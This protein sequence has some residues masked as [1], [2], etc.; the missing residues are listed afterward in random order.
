[1]Q[2]VPKQTTRTGGLQAHWEQV[3]TKCSSLSAHEFEQ[4]HAKGP[5][6]KEA[7]RQ[8][9]SFNTTATAGSILP[10]LRPEGS[11][12]LNFAAAGSEDRSLLKSGAPA[13]RSATP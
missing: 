1:M 6:A 10:T 3:P 12:R 7:T 2:A 5:Y 11:R 13:G 9:S 8:G 4:L